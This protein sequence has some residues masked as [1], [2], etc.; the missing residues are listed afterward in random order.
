MTVTSQLVDVLPTAWR[1]T[2]FKNNNLLG[3]EGFA[4]NLEKLLASSKQQNDKLSTQLGEMNDSL[5]EIQRQLKQTAKENKDL[6]K[7]NFTLNNTLM[8]LKGTQASTPN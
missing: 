7:E 2:T 1:G 4:E 6:A 5:K 3:R 8:N